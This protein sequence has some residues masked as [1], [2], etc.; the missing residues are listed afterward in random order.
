MK[1][2]GGIIGLTICYILNKYVAASPDMDIKK[3][4]SLNK[5]H[6]FGPAVA[7]FYF[8]FKVWKQLC[9][10][11]ASRQFRGEMPHAFHMWWLR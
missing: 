1:G 10:K 7:S 8:S 11:V 4:L 3:V 6:L 9:L 2:D 5:P